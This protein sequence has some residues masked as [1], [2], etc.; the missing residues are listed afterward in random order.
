MEIDY[1]NRIALEVVKKM[2]NLSSENEH[3]NNDD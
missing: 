3:Q 1:L 2:N